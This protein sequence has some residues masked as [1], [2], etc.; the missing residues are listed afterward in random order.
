MALSAGLP[1]GKSSLHSRVD[2]F[3]EAKEGLRV[4]LRA[5]KPVLTLP[6]SIFALSLGRHAQL[7]ELDMRDVDGLF[8][9]FFRSLHPGSSTF[10]T[11]RHIDRLV[12]DYGRSRS[13][14]HASSSIVGKLSD[15]LDRLG[16]CFKGRFSRSYTNAWVS[17]FSTGKDKGWRLTMDFKQGMGAVEAASFEI[18][19]PGGILNP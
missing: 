11:L 5:L 19:R 2:D 7:E 10:R 9:Q 13:P 4:V 8:H 16:L 14:A 15:T 3:V 17:R 18:A 6:W 12:L 1:F